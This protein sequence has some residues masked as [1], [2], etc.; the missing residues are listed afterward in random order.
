[1]KSVLSHFFN[2]F[3]YLLYGF[4][5]LKNKRYRPYIVWPIMLSVLLYVAFFWVAI[6]IGDL[7]FQWWDSWI[8][9]WLHWMNVI[10][11][12][13]GFIFLM[14]VL[15][16]LFTAI[17]NIIA[18]PF[19]ASLATLI[20]QHHS[21]TVSNVH[22]A[23]ASLIKTIWRQCKRQLQLTWFFISRLLLGLVLFLIPGLQ[24]VAGF[25][26]FG[27]NAWLMSLQY[28]DYPME[29]AGLSARETRK[30]L[31]RH[32]PLTLGFGVAVLLCT[33]IPII[34]CAVI[35]AAVIAASRLW[36]DYYSVNTV[37]SV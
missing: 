9:S 24:V 22:P 8:P 26:W 18:A 4:S 10:L 16:F 19:N 27:L 1:M 20:V 3:F 12:S 13:L 36:L 33:F 23:P 34:N 28:C 2:G 31:T 5:E 15:V 29:Y 25:I 11:W 32:A 37:S 14:A 21:D 7:F 17:I 35:P 30:T 6:T